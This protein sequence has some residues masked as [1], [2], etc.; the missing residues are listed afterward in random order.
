MD[1]VPN[2]EANK[3]P[4]SASSFPLPFSG[5]NAKCGDDDRGR[6]GGRNF[7]AIFRRGL[8]FS[9]LPVISK[10]APIY[11]VR[12]GWYPIKTIVRSGGQVVKKGL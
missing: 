2:S 1:L 7:L 5:H 11:D 9:L 3:Q 12:S 6:K 10:G 8:G 4:N